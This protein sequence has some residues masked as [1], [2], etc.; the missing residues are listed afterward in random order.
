MC[1]CVCMWLGVDMGYGG[2]SMC[3]G[4]CGVSVCGGYV[5]VYVCRCGCVTGCGYG[6][7]RD[8]YVCG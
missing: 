5:S 1:E 3:V 7:W 8:E 4:R 6:V 2:V